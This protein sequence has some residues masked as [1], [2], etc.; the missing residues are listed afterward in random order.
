[1]SEP[2]GRPD[3]HRHGRPA[4][5]ALARGR[6]FE[7]FLAGEVFRLGEIALSADEIVA[8][9]SAFDPQPFHLDPVAGARSM[10]GGLAASGWHVAVRLNH[11]LSER[12]LDGSAARRLVAVPEIRW[13][14]PV[15]PD[16]PLAVT[17]RID[18][19]DPGP[20]PDEGT[21]SIVADATD[22]DGALVTRMALRLAVARLV[23]GPAGPPDDPA[24]AHEATRTDGAATAPALARST[25]GRP[26]AW[27]EDVEPEVE[28]VF[29]EGRVGAAEAAAFAEAHD[30]LRLAVAPSDRDVHGV[31]GW[32]LGCA[33]MAGWVEAMGLSGKDADREGGAGPAIGVDEIVWPAAVRPGE[34]LVFFTRVL[35][36]RPS[37]SRPGWGLHVRENGVRRA[38]GR[39]AM[40]FRSTVFARRRTG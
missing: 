32:H 23:P 9:A 5:G 11:R 35:E 8:F 1:M 4:A 17:A 29:G 25:A 34:P 6:R 36:R 38:D 24:T 2:A 39:L 31:D 3:P 7:D 26:G 37:G 33:W 19:L 22:G 27:Y 30:P 28:V 20:T 14:R 40:R 13:R 16:A 21:V 18:A 10:L 12:L 15:H